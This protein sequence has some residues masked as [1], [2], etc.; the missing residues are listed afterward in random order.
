LTAWGTFTAQSAIANPPSAIPVGDPWAAYNRGVE[1]YANGD[2]ETADQTWLE[3][4]NLQ[5]P[6]KLRQPVWFQI[7]NA[8]FRLGEPLETTAPEQAVD[9]WRR[10]CDAYRTVLATNRRHASARHNLAL[11]ERRLASLAHRLGR[12]L[13]EKSES[14]SLDDAINTLGVS[15][16]YLREA[17]QLMP[18][19]EPMAADR[20][21]AE[22]RLQ[23]RL[24]ER[25]N[26]AENRGDQA[27]A[28][29]NSWSNFQA[30][31]SYRTALDDLGEALQPRRD[32]TEE[33]TSSDAHRP[34]QSAPAA[35]PPR[36]GDLEPEL[37]KAQERVTQKL[38]QLLTRLGQEEQKSGE[39]ATSWSAEEAL[40]HFDQA[41]QHYEAAQEV[42]PRNE[43]A[44]RGEAEVRAAI[45]KLHVRE[46][47]QNLARGIQATPNNV[48]QAARE[49]TAALGHAEAALDANPSSLDAVELGNEARRR[50]PDVLARLG[51][52]QQA[53]GQ[54]AEAQSPAA[55]VPRYEEAEMSYRDAL[56]LDSRHTPARTGLNE[57]EE[58]LARLRAQMA[59]AAQAQQGQPQASNQRPRTL[60]DLLGEVRQNDRDREP[61]VDRRRQSGRRDTSPRPVYPN[62]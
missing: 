12:E 51:Q 62:W 6:R 40:N 46:G 50:L 47:R 31:Q 54:R 59:Q 61:Q 5:L 24:L 60:Q 55:A 21:A 10:S 13:R 23:Q 53:A 30:E 45:E 9:S 57:V 19:D 42:D 34:A 7:G 22:R 43:P 3:L 27:V 32:L 33:P 26:Q 17:T 20:A 8:E 2:F 52:Q 18:A 29:N 11:V 1:A 39:S 36:P 58:R 28:Q 56:D 14:Q 37:Q 41:L 38:T 48:P 15:V 25:A 44:Q 49:L 4:A 35:A 16:D